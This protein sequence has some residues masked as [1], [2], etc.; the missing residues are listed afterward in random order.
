MDAER[1]RRGMVLLGEGQVEE[2]NK[3]HKD[4]KPKPKGQVRT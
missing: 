1:K 2:L 4:D 3:A